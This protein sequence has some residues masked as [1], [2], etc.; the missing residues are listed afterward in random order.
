MDDSVFMVIVIFIII[1]GV[2]LGVVANQREQE[3][4]SKMSA[5]ERAA[6]LAKKRATAATLTWG[7]LNPNLLCP[8]CQTR[9]KVRTANVKLKKG[10]SGG[11]AAAAVLTGGVSLLATGLSRKEAT[12]RAHCDK[13]D[14]TWH[15]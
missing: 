11:K 14:S 7:P 6:Y 2:I 4:L 8:H 3:A 13:C 9:G 5:E 12:T 10:V 1:G 15:F